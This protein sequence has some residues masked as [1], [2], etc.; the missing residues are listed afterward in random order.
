MIDPTETDI[1]RKVIYTPSGDYPDKVIEEGVLSSFNDSYV[2]VR[3]GGNVTAAACLRANLDWL[4][5]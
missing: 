3:F 5:G 4:R 2:F 1:G